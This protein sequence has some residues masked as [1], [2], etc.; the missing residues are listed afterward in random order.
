MIS[1]DDSKD[2]LNTRKNAG[3][4]LDLLL[5]WFNDPAY[6][7]GTFKEYESHVMSTRAE[8]LEIVD[9]MLA[10]LGTFVILAADEVEMSITGIIENIRAFVEDRLTPPS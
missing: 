9:G 7:K 2:L 1:N 6:D 10:V 3:Q 4:A 8:T 5:A